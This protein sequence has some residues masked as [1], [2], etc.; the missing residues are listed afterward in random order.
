MW[1]EILKNSFNHLWELILLIISVVIPIIIAFVPSILGKI[2]GKIYIIVILF[3]IIIIMILIKL[4]FTTLM[5]I[6]KHKKLIPTLKNIKSGKYIFEPSELFATNMPVSLY[7]IDD[8]E[9]HIGLGYVETVITRSKCLQ[10]KIT[11]IN[12]EDSFFIK[13]KDKIIL[14]P[15]AIINIADILENITQPGDRINE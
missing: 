14:K 7:Y 9:E 12:G 8:I 1:K 13:N 5:I 15:F 3:L 4:F 2:N 6:D 10:V 11:K